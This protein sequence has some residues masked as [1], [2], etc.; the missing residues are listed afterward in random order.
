MKE[1]ER[2]VA[3][4]RNGAKLEFGN[5]EAFISYLTEAR[6]ILLTNASLLEY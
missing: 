6:R 3:D 5:R 2:F 4:T 1:G